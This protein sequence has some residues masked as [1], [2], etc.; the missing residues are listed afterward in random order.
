MFPSRKHHLILCSLVT[1]LEKM[2]SEISLLTNKDC[3]EDFGC[4]SFPKDC[5]DE[6]CHGIL[7][8]KLLN[9]RHFRFEMQAK[10]VSNFEQ[11]RY[12][13]F[14]FSEDTFMGDDTVIECVIDADGISGTTFISFNEGLNNV[15]LLDASEKMM[16]DREILLKDGKMVCKF[17]LDMT[18]TDVEEDEKASIYDLHNSTW[19]LLFASGSTIPST[20]EKLI[21]SLDEGDEFYPWK[22]T[23]EIRLDQNTVVTEMRQ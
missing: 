19:T 12:M 8:W 5:V 16:K 11:G 3:G 18:M 1:L 6:E 10:D 9:Q 21:H 17:E 15:Q 20:G 13:A 23:E 22:T 7:K 4:W 14:G 2:A